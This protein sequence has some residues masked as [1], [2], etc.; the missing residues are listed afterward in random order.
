MQCDDYC[1]NSGRCDTCNTC[2]KVV[3]CIVISRAAMCQT[4][5]P[6]AYPAA[7]RNEDFIV[8]AELIAISHSGLNRQAVQTTTVNVWVQLGVRGIVRARTVVVEIA[9]SK[10]L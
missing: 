5:A 10:L 8:V 7:G 4:S 9:V 3:T 6:C 2:T 1:N